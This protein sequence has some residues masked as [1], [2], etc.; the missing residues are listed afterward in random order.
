[1]KRNA[2]NT[3]PDDRRRREAIEWR[4]TPCVFVLL[5]AC[6]VCEC[7]DYRR[8][9]T[10]GNGDGSRTRKVVCANE[11]CGQPFKIVFEPP[12]PEMGNEPIEG[13]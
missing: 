12:L 11:S 7:T 13:L 1:M 3:T 2:E 4:E 6:P 10:E 8:V 9:R 5:P